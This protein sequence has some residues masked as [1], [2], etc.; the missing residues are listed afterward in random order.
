MEN[1]AQ[2]KKRVLKEDPELRK[3]YEALQ[4]EFEIAKAIIKQRIGKKLTQAQLAKKLKTKQS[5][6]SRLESGDYNP[7]IGFLKKVA[8]ALNLTL[9]VSLN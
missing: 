6:I 1:F 3:A 8:E 2:F 4:P 7:T 5:A 9:K